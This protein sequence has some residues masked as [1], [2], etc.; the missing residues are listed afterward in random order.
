MSNAAAIA[1][2]ATEYQRLLNR[3]SNT[4][5]TMKVQNPGDTMTAV[6][7]AMVVSGTCRMLSSCGTEIKMIPPYIPKT[8]LVRPISHI[9]AT[10][11]GVIG[12]RVSTLP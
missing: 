6:I 5:L 3:T 10:D 7:A 8:E 2:L 11:R 9:G 1:A 12:V 4:G